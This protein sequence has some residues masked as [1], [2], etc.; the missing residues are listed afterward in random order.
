MHF[1]FHFSSVSVILFAIAALSL[2]YICAIYCARLTS[3]KKIK[4]DCNAEPMPESAPGVSV[5]VYATDMPATLTR[6]LPKLMKQNYPGKY[7]VIVVNDGSSPDINMVVGSLKR[8]HKNIYLTFT[9]EGGHNISRKK[10][11]ITLGVKAANHQYVVICDAATNI[12]SDLWL[13]SMMRHFNNPATEV[14]LG[15]G[16]PD[17][18]QTASAIA[19]DAAADAATWI[20]AASRKRPYRGCG[21]NLAYKRELFFSHNGFSQSINLRDGDDDLFV[22]DI[23]DPD[24][25]VVELSE[26]SIASHDTSAPR[27]ELR[28]FRASHAFTGRRLPKSPRRIMAFGEWLMWVATA[29]SVAGALTAGARNMAGWAIAAAMI[30][31]MLITAGLCW[32]SATR[33]LMLPCPWWLAG[34]LAMTRPLRNIGARLRSRASSFSHFTWQ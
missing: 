28:D 7:E 22:H 21:Y 32:R 26:N 3:I 10:L 19:F 34:I 5:I 1:D 30:L 2:I 11:A 4:A 15:Y 17:L 23:A 20:H 12:E 33:A 14:V 25:T 18:K 27:R 31:A 24:N 9:P 29:C 13:A 6:N 8:S 16:K